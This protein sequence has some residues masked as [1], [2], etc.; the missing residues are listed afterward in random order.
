MTTINGKI[1]AYK[2]VFEDIITS[3]N[4]YYKEKDNQILMY[5]K[6]KEFGILSFG[7]ITFEEKITVSIDG[8]KKSF[9]YNDEING[10]DK[11]IMYLVKNI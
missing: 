10:I 1:N 3:E 11:S 9:K 4:Y 7:R 8:F 6:D 2:K 5:A